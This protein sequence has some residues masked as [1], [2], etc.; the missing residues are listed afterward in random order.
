VVP[1]ILRAAGIEESERRIFISYVRKESMSAAEQ[2]FDELNRR[3]F[4]VYLDRFRG[5]PG[6]DFR[7]KLMR[8]LAHKSMVVLLGTPGVHQSPWTMFEL[9]IARMY[10]LGIL[11]FDLSPAF[12]G[13]ASIRGLPLISSEVRSLARSSLV[14][15][16][17][18]V[19][20]RKAAVTECGEAV[21]NAHTQALLA[22]RQRLVLTVDALLR[23]VG[24]RVLST[25]PGGRVMAAPAGRS[26]L[27]KSY[28]IR[29]SPRPAELTDFHLSHSY[30][31]A[32]TP[33]VAAPASWER[34][35][36]RDMISWLETVSAVRLV[37]EGNWLRAALDVKR[38]LL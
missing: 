32:A 7:Q 35:A 36:T 6:A 29:V 22:R 3:N 2:L 5:Q 38:G 31:G 19:A 14:R 27:T 24:A 18:T 4:D 21:A 12:G 25:D 28:S 15:G 23:H 11:V 13:K 8:E 20:F 34:G 26:G 33:I 1:D 17:R 9:L 37:E 16:R 30:A 10:G